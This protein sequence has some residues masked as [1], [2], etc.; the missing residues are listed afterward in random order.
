MSNQAIV[1]PIDKKDPEFLRQRQAEYQRDY[2]KRE[3]E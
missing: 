3:A 2:R 1:A